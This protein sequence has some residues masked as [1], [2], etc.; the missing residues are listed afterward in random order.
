M[1]KEKVKRETA[2]YEKISEIIDLR[3]ADS[4]DL[5][6]EQIQLKYDRIKQETKLINMNEM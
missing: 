5:M 2:R 6:K 4:N 1:D 3:D